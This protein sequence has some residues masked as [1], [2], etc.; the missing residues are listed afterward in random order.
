[1]YGNNNLRKYTDGCFVLFD[2][3][4][5]KGNGVYA[6]PEGSSKLASRRFD[7]ILGAYEHYLYPFKKTSREGARFR[8]P[9]DKTIYLRSK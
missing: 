1:M 5:T 4:N 3:Y 7:N 6:E 8:T 2:A 9:I